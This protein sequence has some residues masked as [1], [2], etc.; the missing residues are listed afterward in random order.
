MLRSINKSNGYSIKVFLEFI[1]NICNQ[2]VE[3]DQL[4]DLAQ[5]IKYSVEKISS[6]INLNPEILQIGARDLSFSLYRVFTG[7]FQSLNFN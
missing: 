5:K 7:N 4:R 2:A 1:L 6:L 3:L